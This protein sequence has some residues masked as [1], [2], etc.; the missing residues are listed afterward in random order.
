[1]KGS[2]RGS[3]NPR[4]GQQPFRP[5]PNG[6]GD[7]TTTQRR[8]LI[9]ADTLECG[10]CICTCHFISKVF[11]ITIY[12]LDLLYFRTKM[13]QFTNYDVSLVK[14]LLFT[15]FLLRLTFF[16]CFNRLKG[17]KRFLLSVRIMY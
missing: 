8:L 14:N 2:A 4:E 1:M 10:R 16:E 15:L 13:C 5:N 17:K 11:A 3:W 12:D 6:V 9:G 7:H